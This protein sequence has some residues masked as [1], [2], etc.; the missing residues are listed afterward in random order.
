[1]L[2]G[3]PQS[4]LAEGIATT[5]LGA[6]GEEA[7]DA[8]AELLAGLGAAYDLQQV[9]AARPAE[10][11][12][13]RVSHTVGLM[14]HEEG[15][16]PEEARAYAR[17]WSLRTEAEIDKLL[18]FGQHPAWRAYVVVYEVGERLVRA[19]TEGDPARYR[20]LLTEQLTTAD[21]LEP[22]RRSA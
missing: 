4:V 16:D 14:L 6:L 17:R 20:R 21:L 7:E 2:T 3:T 15:R 8:C 22:D 5:A 19:W 13:R 9:R 1:M 10:R 12:L 18:A 11:T